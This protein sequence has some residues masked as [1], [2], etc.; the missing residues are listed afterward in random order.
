M[1]LFGKAIGLGMAGRF[2]K[3]IGAIAAL[4]LAGWAGSAS[5]DGFSSLNVGISYLNRERYAD[6][7]I[8][9]DKAIT[10]KDLN[11]DQMHVAYMDRGKAYV[12]LNRPQE[13]VADFTAALAIRPDD[14]DVLLDRSFAYV[15]AGQPEKAAED[16]TSAPISTSTIPWVALFRGLVAWELGRYQA[17]SDAFTILADK[18]YTDGWLWLQLANAKQKKP[19]TKY[20][21][22]TFLDGR[23]YTSGIPYY[24][25]GPLMFHYAGQRS[26]QDVFSALEDYYA[27]KTAECQANFYLGELRMAHGD[28]AGA[29]TLLQKAVNVCQAGGME[30]RMAKFE[31]K[32]L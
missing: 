29:K 32:K 26:E 11:P 23:K 12:Q 3:S 6:A 1:K 13:A 8:W 9:L 4:L 28:A 27:S 7:I 25:P 20:P 31:M 24:W 10:A 18:G 17:A 30:W 5:A 22:M 2:S 15:D 16:I 14:L 21:G 19:G